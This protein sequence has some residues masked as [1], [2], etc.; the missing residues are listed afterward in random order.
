MQMT[1]SLLSMKNYNETLLKIISLI[2]LDVFLLINNLFYVGVA[3]FLRLPNVLRVYS[4]VPR[5][6]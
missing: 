3:N 4:S 2:V 1:A 6:S 5:G